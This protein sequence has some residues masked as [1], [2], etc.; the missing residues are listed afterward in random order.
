[1]KQ[2]RAGTN[3][4]LQGRAAQRG[5]VERTLTGLFGGAPVSGA[6]PYDLI[7]CG[8]GLLQGFKLIQELRQL[9]NVLGLQ[10]QWVL[11]LDLRHLALEVGPGRWQCYLRAVQHFGY[12]VHVIIE[13]ERLHC[14]WH[15]RIHLQYSDRILD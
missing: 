7:D 2:A 10:R 13:I 9:L 15:G 14:S 8:H 4:A 3:R 5:L 1:M 6:P 12:I 11:G